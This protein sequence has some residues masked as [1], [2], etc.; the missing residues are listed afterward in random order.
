M[1]IYFRND[2]YRYHHNDKG[3]SMQST[4]PTHIYHTTLYYYH[5]RHNHH[6]TTYI[7]PLQQWKP[8]Y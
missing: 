6:D 4:S 7:S 2:V 8:K 3:T 1:E 5:H